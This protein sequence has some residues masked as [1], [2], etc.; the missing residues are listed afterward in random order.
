MKHLHKYALSAA[1]GLA[2]TSAFA[3]QWY[4]EMDYGRFLTATYNNSEG[5][6]TFDKKGCAANK[7]IAIK[8][9]KDN[10]GAMVFDTDLL[11]MAGGWTDGF[12][13]C[14]G[15]A[16]DGAHGPNPHPPEKAQIIF[17]TNP[18]SPGWSKGDDFKDPRKLPTG[19]GAA[20]VPF[21]PLPKEWAKYKGLYLNG[22]NVVLAYTVGAAAVL[23]SP[24]IE[25]NGD[26]SSITRTFNV[27]SKGSEASSL[28]VA[29]GAENANATV[30]SNIVAL[31]DPKNPDGRTFIAV[32]GA[33]NGAKWQ[34]VPPARV[35]LKLPTFSGNEAFKII[36]WKGA[37]SDLSKGLQ[38][39]KTV[40]N[41]RDLT[42][43]GPAHWSQ[44][45]TST[46]E[47]SQDKNSPYVVDTIGIPSD[48]PFKSKIR[49]GGLDFF[50]DGRIAFSTWNGDVW[51]GTPSDAEYS[52]V[53]W[54][55]F[56]TGL[57]Q[58]LGLKI[59]DDQIYVLGRDQIT[60]LHDLNNDGEADLY[61]NFNNDIQV[62]PGFHE[63]AF[64]LQTDPQGNF[65]FVKGGPVNPGGR[66][67]GPLSEHNG[68]MFKISKD[69]QKFE[70]FATGLRAP[71]GMGI[72]PSGEITNG[73]NQ[74][75]WVPV[76]YIHFVKQGEFIEVPDLAHKATPPTEHSQHL[77]W[78]PY[79]WDN[80]CG[81][82]TWVPNDNW[83]LAK[84]TMLYLS[85]GKCSL[86]RVLID[87]FGNVMQGGVVKF[88]LKFETGIMRARFNPKDGQLYVAGLRG[89]QTTAS[90]DAA[91]Q[92]VRFTGKAVTMPDTLHVTDKGI[93]VRFTA[94]LDTNSAAD[95]Q[96]YSIEQYNYHWT[97]DYGS[98]EFSVTD[99]SK[100]GHDQV[101]IKSV[102]VS[103]DRKEVFLEV[104]G[105]KPVDQMK[106]KMNLKDENGN[107]IPTD[108]GNTINEVAKD[109][110]TA[111][112]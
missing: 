5:K 46:S 47:I 84:N 72:S 90:K 11:R 25:K 104:P 89:W 1:V 50:K 93:H 10:D 7:G 98:P 56:A 61:E 22:D 91:I 81:S 111:S 26:V 30:E 71:N 60:H 32:A 67:W 109:G 77:C 102:R 23:E 65:Y 78:V 40:A 20:Q 19:P 34:I 69:G 80:S 83:G 105:L 110:A 8:L 95:A 51:I 17:Q 16:Y 58:A 94:P 35:E 52:K 18:Q 29:E 100:K 108:I 75:T 48:N 2:A 6:P 101:E 97:K 13:K 62:T 107:P 106:I 37:A 12:V 39:S 28:L 4:D 15:V 33:P 9:G 68:C 79:D 42:K 85:Y 21:G 41:L 76:D 27:L 92:R 55:R 88:P 3:A 54:H 45:V 103:P 66:G 73:D 82:Q 99:P 87:K 96:N 49:I 31:T 63:F 53:T 38:A 59:V 36:Y 43:G 57:F 64:D 86:F 74:G 70:V 44:T 112:L 24:G 14:Q